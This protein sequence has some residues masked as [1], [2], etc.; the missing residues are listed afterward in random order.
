MEAL[1]VNPNLSSSKMDRKHDQILADRD[2]F[3]KLLMAQLQ[4]QTPTSPMDPTQFTQQ[5]VMLSQAE[6][7]V[8]TNQFLEKLVGMYQNT[9]SSSVV[10]YI[11]KEVEY[12]ASMQN[13]YGSNVLFKYNL[14]KEA[15]DV[16]IEIYDKDG[17]F[18]TGGKGTNKQGL[19]EFVWDGTNQEGEIMPQGDYIMQVKAKDAYGGYVRSHSFIR[20]KVIGVSDLYN[21]PI[22]ETTDGNVTIE[23]I[24]AIKESKEEKLVTDK[25][26]NIEQ[27]IKEEGEKM[28]NELIG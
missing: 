7:G 14:E 2:T 23:R 5:I 8:Q 24:L 12:D 13:F 21:N 1:P 9:Q 20:S 18:V 3:L 27:I 19:N 10:N 15:L 16:D 26:N 11:G 17:K 28:L 25:K 6:Q 4:Y 22:L